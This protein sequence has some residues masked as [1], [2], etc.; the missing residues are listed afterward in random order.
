MGGSLKLGLP[1]MVF[2]GATAT[3]AASWSGLGEARH[4]GAVVFT[5]AGGSTATTLL[6]VD[7]TMP[8]PEQNVE[9]K[10]A[11]SRN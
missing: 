5:G 3:V 10:L 7:T 2:T 8:I 1:S 9:R 6:E 11:E 4:L